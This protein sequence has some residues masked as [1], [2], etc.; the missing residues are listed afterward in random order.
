M[1]QERLPAAR[2]A[3]CAGHEDGHD[4][5][6]DRGLALGQDLAQLSCPDRHRNRGL[7]RD[8]AAVRPG[9]GAGEQ[10]F[11]PPDNRSRIAQYHPHDVPEQG[12]ERRADDATGGRTDLYS[13][14]AGR[15]G[16][17]HDGRGHCQCRGDRRYRG[18]IDR[19]HPGQCRQGQGLLAKGSGPHGRKGQAHAGGRRRGPRPDHG[20]HGL[21]PA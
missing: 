21:C 5:H 9:A 15:S 14:E 13:Q 16:C 17:G 7:R 12:Q 11:R 10:V 8:A 18:H 3:W 1:G 2:G 6:D 20:D 19:R 4:T